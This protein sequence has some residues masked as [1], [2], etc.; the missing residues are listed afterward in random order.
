MVF[1][2][3][4]IGIRKNDRLDILGFEDFLC[5]TIMKGERERESLGV[6]DMRRG[7]AAFFSLK[8]VYERCLHS[9]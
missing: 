9:K 5:G 6:S 1:I 4:S 8:L 2:T 3:I 7:R